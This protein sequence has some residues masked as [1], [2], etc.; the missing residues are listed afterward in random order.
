M[1]T[2]CIQVYNNT[3]VDPT[4]YLTGMFQYFQKH[5]VTLNY[6]IASVN[7]QPLRS[8]RAYNPQVGTVDVLNPVHLPPTDHDI[9]LF[10]YDYSAWKSPWYWPWPLWNYGAA[11]NVPRDDTYMDGGKPVITIGYWQ[12]DT[13]VAQRFLHE[14]MHAVAKLFSCQDVMDSYLLDST[15][16][17]PGGNFAQQWAIFQPYLNTM[18]PTV[19]QSTLDFLTQNEG[20]VLHPYQDVK[21]NWTIG[22]GFTRLNGETVSQNTPSFASVQD[23]ENALKT[24]IQPYA[25][26]ISS[27]VTYPINQNQF[28]ALVSLCYN[29][30]QSA[31]RNSTLVRDLNAGLVQ[32][33]ADQFLVWDIPAV[34]LAR[35]QKERALFLS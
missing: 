8:A 32:Q 13:T 29:E 25:D 17:A 10:L 34:L 24:V 14:P 18:K 5:G 27:C 35:R 9:V 11:G 26:T 2:Y 30:G 33:A 16:D 3:S 19:Q 4:P 28:D 20:C 21:G 7:I 12:T 22:I 15:P 31:I 23:A 6:D 1:K